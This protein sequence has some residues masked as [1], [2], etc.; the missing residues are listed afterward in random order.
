MMK[1][2]SGAHL[3]AAEVTKLSHKELAR[4]SEICGSKVGALNQ[5]SHHASFIFCYHFSRKSLLT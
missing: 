5:L 4:M 1:C 2:T 3:K